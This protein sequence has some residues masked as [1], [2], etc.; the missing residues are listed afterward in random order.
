[1]GSAWQT[2]FLFKSLFMIR[3]QDLGPS[4]F[5][6]LRQ[7]KTLM[8][9]GVITLGGNANLKIYGLLSCPSGK[10]M[11]PANHVFFQNEQEALAHGYRPCGHCLR[12]KYRVW[13]A[14]DL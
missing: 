3:H 12:E 13:K 7:L 1:V 6:Q 2:L 10:R 8:D 11:K 4:S 5:T 14:K 9:A